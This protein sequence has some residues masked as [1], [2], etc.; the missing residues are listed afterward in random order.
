MLGPKNYEYYF[1]Q[2]F[3]QLGEK[4]LDKKDI[5]KLSS[6]SGMN[7]YFRTAAQRFRFIE[8]DWQETVVVPYGSAIELLARLTSEPWN[9]RALLRNLGRYSIGIPRRLFTL[10]AQKKYVRETGFPDLFLLDYAL[11]DDTYGF[12]TPN[13]SVGIDP[14]KFYT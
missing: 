8:D 11:Y 1:R 13:D 7:Y 5:L 2:R 4:A 12:I 3:W 10:L 14:D 6:G 9:Q